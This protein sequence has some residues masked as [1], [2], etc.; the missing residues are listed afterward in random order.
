MDIDPILERQV[1]LV[2]ENVEQ[3]MDEAGGELFGFGKKE[4]ITIFVP[5]AYTYL[6]LYLGMLG[7]DPGIPV[8]AWGHHQEAFKRKYKGQRGA[9]RGFIE[10]IVEDAM[11]EQFNKLNSRVHPLIEKSDYLQ[12]FEE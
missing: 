10:Y 7:G 8:T 1:G 9:M 3:L 12:G 2:C 4:K 5:K 6:A 11:T